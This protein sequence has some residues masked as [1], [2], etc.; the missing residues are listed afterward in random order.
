LYLTFFRRRKSR[1]LCFWCSKQAHEWAD[2][3]LER[4]VVAARRARSVDELTSVERV[5]N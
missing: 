1:R 3:M 5:P 2:T 4:K